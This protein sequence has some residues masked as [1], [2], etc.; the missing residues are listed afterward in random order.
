MPQAANFRGLPGV[1]TIAV[2]LC[3]MAGTAK[4]IDANIRRRQGMVIRL[5]AITAILAG[6]WA[7]HAVLAQEPGDAEKGLAY[8]SQV[9]AQCHALQRGDLYSPMPKAPAFEEIANSAG[10]TGISLAA[11]LHSVHENMPSFVLSEAGRDNIIA[12]ILSLKRRH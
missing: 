5:L 2:I 12:Y 1:S 8:A 6:A 4:E 7:P 11:I 9:C 3:L 10:V